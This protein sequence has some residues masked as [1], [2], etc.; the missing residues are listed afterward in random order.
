MGSFW[1]APVPTVTN[2]NTFVEPPP[3][4]PPVVE[5]QPGHDGGTARVAASGNGPCAAAKCGGSSNNA[6]L[7]ALN[8]RPQRITGG[9]GPTAYDEHAIAWS[10]D[11]NRLAFLSDQS[12]PGQRHLDPL[13][14]V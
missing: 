2:P 9:N 11:S 4:P 6:I 3:P 10:P 7:S 12:Q 5:E 1:L 13:G 14:P 8:A